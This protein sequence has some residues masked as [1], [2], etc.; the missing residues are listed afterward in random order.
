MCTVQKKTCEFLTSNNSKIMFDD[1]HFTVEG[2]K[3]LGNKIKELKW[4]QVFI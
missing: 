4:F 3:Y 2:A 1:S